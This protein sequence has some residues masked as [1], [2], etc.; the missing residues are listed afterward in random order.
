MNVLNHEKPHQKYF[1]EISRI[2]RGSFNEAA[3]ADY[4]AAFAAEHGL[5][6]IRDELN[7]VVIFKPAGAGYEDHGAVILQAHTDR[8]CEKNADCTHDFEKDP[9]DLYIE[10]GILKARGTTL[11]ADD[12]MG[13]AYMLA[14]LASD[15]PHPALECV[16]TVQEEVGLI[17]AFALKPEYFTAKRYVNLDFGGH[18]VGT[19]TTSAG[20]EMIGLRKPVEFDECD[21]P[22]YRIF[23]TGLKGGHSGGCIMM[24]LG[25]SLKIC[26][27]ILKEISGSC[28]MRIRK[29]DGGLKNNAIPRECEAVFASEA[30]EEDIRAAFE[31]M[32]TQIASEIGFQEPDFAVTL[33]RAESG[34]AICEEVSAE[35]VDLLYLLPTGLRHRS[36]QIA[37]LP[38]A[39]ENLASVRTGADYLEFQYSLRAEKM[40]LRDQMEKEICILAGIYD[41][42]MEVYSKFPSWEFNPNSALRETLCRV[43][44]EQKDSEMELLATHGGLE[45]GVFCDMI[46]GLDVVTLGAETDGAHTPK[47][48]MNLESFDRTFDVLAAFLKEL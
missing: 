6:Y 37:N 38:T 13:C 28:D 7:N 1:E 27:R 31:S 8:V 2:P 40:S 12:G 4:L 47:E 18:G 41:M 22:A 21:T 44:K 14:V 42:T 48:Q 20:G 46:P 26:G 10:N 32:K 25:N 34:P 39:S 3:C 30:K 36:L 16:F 29:L 9:I 24:E 43:Y 19:C 5:K 35:I 17:G 15:L 33:E 23:V 45:C 11:G